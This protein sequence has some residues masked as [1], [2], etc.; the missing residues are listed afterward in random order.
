MLRV[1]VFQADSVAHLLSHANLLA[2]TVDKLEVALRKENGEG[3]ARKTTTCAEVEDMRA[4]LEA[5]ETTNGQRM[6]H[7]VF[8]E[9]IDILARDDINLLI[10]FMIQRI[11]G[12]KLRILLI[13]ELG[14]IL[15]NQFHG[16]KIVNKLK[17]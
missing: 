14:K 5:D 15:F 16:A 12:F 13:G 11:E 2:R 9:I 10:P 7:M 1:T 17:I 4:W 8:V 6:E 3:H